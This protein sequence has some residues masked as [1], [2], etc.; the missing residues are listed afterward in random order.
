MLISDKISDECPVL[1][2]YNLLGKKWT[3]PLLMNIKEERYYSF[4]DIIKLTSRQINRTLLSNLLKEM[5]KYNILACGDSGYKIT[6]K[7]VKV[8]NILCDLKKL[9]LKDF[10]EHEICYM[11]SNCLVST[12]KN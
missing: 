6:E 7:G 9:I 5:T 12:F 10:S 2:L 8:K 1:E 4:G 11:K 3:C